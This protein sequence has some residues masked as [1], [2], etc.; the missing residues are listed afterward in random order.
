LPQVDL[1]SIV[2]QEGAHTFKRTV[3]KLEKAGSI[4]LVEG[5]RVDLE[6]FKGWLDAVGRGE[7]KV[8]T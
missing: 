3:F 4:P 7:G 8:I 1:S 2:P 5:Y 6:E